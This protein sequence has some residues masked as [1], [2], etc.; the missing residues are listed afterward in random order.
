MSTTVNSQC[1]FDLGLTRHHV[2]LPLHLILVVLDGQKG[3][4]ANQ[5]DTEADDQT[6]PLVQLST[7]HTQGHRQ[8]AEQQDDRVD[9]TQ[10]R[11]QKV[12]PVVEHLGVI[13]PVHGVGAE[14]AAEEQDFRQQERPHPQ[15]GRA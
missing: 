12:M 5:R 14:Q 11:I 6:S 13:P 15:L 3:Q 4:G 9:R 8:A 10:R 7:T 2:M 1:R